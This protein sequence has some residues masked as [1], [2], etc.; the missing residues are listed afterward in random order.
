MAGT[1]V[2][3]KVLKEREVLLVGDFDEEDVSKN[4]PRS[5]LESAS[6]ILQ[7]VLA[8]DTPLGMIC[9]GHSG[10]DRFD[11]DDVNLCSSVA[12]QAGQA[13]LNFRHRE[14]EAARSRLDRKYVQF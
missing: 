9:L 12:G 5:G 4:L 2:L 8:D 1:G 3:G 13:I 6:M 11:L 14:E 7:P 10:K